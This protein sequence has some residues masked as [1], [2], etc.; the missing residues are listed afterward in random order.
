[1]SALY[2][3]QRAERDL[4]AIEDYSLETWGPKVAA[5][6]MQKFQAAF[7]LLAAS[8]QLVRGREEFVDWLRFYR[9][10]RHW[11]VCAVLSDD[12]YVLAVRHGA[13]DLPRR[14]TELEPQL[15]DEAE[16]MHRRITGQ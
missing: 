2:L 13:M 15:L 10:E 4:I 14:L 8:P 3:T 6:Y 1:M 12:I 7:D 16:I 5:E 11:V 9:V